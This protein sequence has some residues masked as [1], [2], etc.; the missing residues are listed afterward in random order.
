M[1]EDGITPSPPGTKGWDLDLAHGKAGEAFL[2]RIL[3]G[4][5]ETKRDRKTW[6]TRNVVVEFECRGQPSGIATTES[7]WWSFVLDGPDGKPYSTVTVPLARLLTIA[8][9]RYAEGYWRYGGDDN[10]AKMVL[11]PVAML[12]AW[13]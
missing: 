12:V 7:K 6:E 8:G 5:H 4:K 11:V 2:R 13:G 9:R 10:Q 1:N 3:A